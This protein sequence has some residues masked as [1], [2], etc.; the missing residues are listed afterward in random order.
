MPA[1]ERH[2]LAIGGHA[3][4]PGEPM[5][6]FFL[7]LT[8]KSDPKVLFVPTA[9]G[10]SDFYVARFHRAFPASRCRGSHLKLFAIP[11]AD[12]RAFVL[13]QDAIFVGGGNTA[14]M[15]AVWRVHGLDG[16]LRE[17]WER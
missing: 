2:V 12:L 10:D 3:M 4:E 8:G 16:I 11:P 5:N 1:A 15:L 17:A 7:E 14:N 9:T 13:D 6:D